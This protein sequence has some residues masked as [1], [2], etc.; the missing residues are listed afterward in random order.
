MVTLSK[1]VLLLK[2]M[3]F[4]F[5]R[6][7]KAVP[8]ICWSRSPALT[9]SPREKPFEFQP[10]SLYIARSA[11]G[12]AGNGIHPRMKTNHTRDTAARLDLHWIQPSLIA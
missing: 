8:A 11:F 12:N 6:G 4:A 3:S 9:I 7:S 1:R 10:K 5:C 2:L